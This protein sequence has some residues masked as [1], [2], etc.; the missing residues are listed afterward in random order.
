MPSTNVVAQLQDDATNKKR[1]IEDINYR[2]SW[3]KHQKGLKDRE[4]AEAEK[5]R[6]AYASIDWHDF[7]VVQTVD[8]QPGDT[9][10]L[11]PLCTPKDVGARILLEA[12]NEMQ[13]AAAE[14]Q[15]MDMEESDSDD[16]DAVQGAFLEHFT[17][18]IDKIH[19]FPVFS[20]S[21]TFKI[22]GK[23][24]QTMKTLKFKFKCFQPG[25]FKIFRRIHILFRRKR[26]KIAILS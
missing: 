25:I 7:V 11:P 13:K 16:E 14:M 2:V 5:E 22:D 4:E 18:K 24:W 26:T 8:F 12:R 17:L 1:L 6:Q 3:E 23:Q 20:N 9:S 21:F 19:F 10:Q 15:E